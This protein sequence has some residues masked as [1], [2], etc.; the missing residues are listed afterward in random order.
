[1]LEHAEMAEL[2]VDDLINEVI[3]TKQKPE[4]LLTSNISCALHISARLA[5]R[6]VELDLIHPVTLIARQLTP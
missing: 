1:M 3:S 4:Y 5:E 6:K 2:L